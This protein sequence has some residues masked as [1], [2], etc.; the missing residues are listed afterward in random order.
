MNKRIQATPMAGA[1]SA[2][3]AMLGHGAAFAQAPSPGDG[4][5]IETIDKVVVT[6]TRREGGLQDVAAAVTAI[7]AKDLAR[8]QITDIKA[9]SARAPSLL[10]TDTP[11]GK[12]NMII[13]MRGITPTSISSN[14]DPT[15]GIYVNGV[16]YARSAGAN[17]ALVDMQ[18]IE[19][20]RGPQGTLFGRNTIGGALNM[21]TQRPTDRLEG[22]LQLGLGDYQQRTA[23]AIVNVPLAGETLAA[24][25]VVDHAEHG[26]YGRTTTLNQELGDEK[27]DY[28]RATLRLRPTDQW[29]IDLYLDQFK[30]RA[31]SQIWTL[32]YFDPAIAK[33]APLTGLA[34]YL[35]SGGF[36]STA[37]FNPKN[38]ADVYNQV[39]TASYTADAFTLKSISAYRKIDVISGY[40]LD[41]TPVFVNQIQR[42]GVTGNQVSQELQAYGD[43]LDGRL[44]WITGLYYFKE[45]LTD[46]SLVTSPSGSN[47]LARLNQFEVDQTSTS[48]FGQLTWSFTKNLRATAGARAVHDQRSINYYLPRY[49]AETGASLT[50]NAGCALAAPGLDQG[51]CHYAPPE[52]KF[53]YVPWTLGLDYKPDGRNLIY[54]K[55]SN[56]YRSGGFQPGG[57]VTAGGYLPFDK[58]QVIAYEAGAK[59]VGLDNRLRLNVAAYLSKYTDIQQ[60]APNIPPGSTVTI[61]SVINAGK[62]TVKGLELDSQLRLNG[63]E[64]SAGLGLMNPKFTSGPYEGQPFVTAAKVTYNLG[65]DVPVVLALGRLNLHA[66]YNWRSKVSF[67]V[68][69]NTNTTPFSPLTAGQISSNEQAGYGL[70]NALASLDITGTRLRVSLWGRNLTNQYYKARSNSFYLQ[71]YNTVTPGDPRTLGVALDY[72]FL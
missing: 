39:L 45:S 5:A 48:F 47:T 72:K 66:D 10:I 55:V 17:A 40:D 15:V 27:R 65:L 50:G 21:S 1:A 34:P 24:R 2:L 18:Q 25:V 23:Q 13:G 41:A 9:L 42:Y 43:A 4:L 51:G 56:G 3:A 69:V 14:N 28:V 38:T 8:E 52:L 11:V 36:D 37:G 61:S 44:D 6:A 7:T 31:N 49:T 22:S 29:D 53:H 60:L 12:N 46:S 58:E 20:I 68:P 35:T 30:N 70:L 26:G 64:L 33:T 54:G 57:A 67:F 19:V 71:G 62:A 32:T 63:F 16:Y 59:W